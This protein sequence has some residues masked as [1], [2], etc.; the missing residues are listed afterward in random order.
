MFF[1]QDVREGVTNYVNL[2]TSLFPTTSLVKSIDT[3]VAIF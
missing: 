3:Q 1:Q 2:K